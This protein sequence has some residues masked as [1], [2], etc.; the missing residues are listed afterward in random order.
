MVRLLRQRS[1]YTIMCTVRRVYPMY[2]VVTGSASLLPLLET[3]SHRVYM[4]P[5]DSDFTNLVS[6]SLI[7][8]AASVRFGQTE[9]KPNSSVHIVRKMWRGSVLVGTVVSYGSKSWRLGGTLK[10]RFNR[11][12]MVFVLALGHVGSAQQLPRPAH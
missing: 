9:L 8:Q 12:G 4:G 1:T 10:S 11:S 6:R 5:V 7:D 3:Q 2:L